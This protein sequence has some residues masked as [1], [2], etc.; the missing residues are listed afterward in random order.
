[1][2]V[3][4]DSAYGALP[5]GTGRNVSRAI[6]AAEAAQ[7]I[8]GYSDP[9][10]MVRIASPFARFLEPETGRFHG[11]YGTRVG[12]QVLFAL[13][14]LTADRDTRQAVITLWDPIRDNE[15]DRRDYPCTVAL[16]LSLWNDRLDLDVVMRSNDV[17]LGAA[18][19]WF[20]FTQLQL[21]CARALGVAPGVYRHTAWSLHI[22]ETDIERAQQ[23][24][25]DPTRAVEWQPEGL[26][27]PGQNFYD[28]QQRAL[29]LRYPDDPRRADDTPSE[30]WYREHLAPFTAGRTP[31]GVVD[32]S[33]AVT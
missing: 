3:A 30:R 29:A 27:R 2:T 10:L 14:K 25:V 8:G 18:F 6:G 17:W 33:G 24:A 26:G 11:A 31:H 1:V 7:L 16:R 5:L 9:D 21:T 12:N 13:N 19:D 4:L 32:R 23:L 15:P 22:Y 28:I 20:Q